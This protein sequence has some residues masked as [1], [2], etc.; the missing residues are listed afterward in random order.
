MSSKLYKKWMKARTAL[1]AAT[2]NESQ[3]REEIMLGMEDDK[4]KVTVGD[5]IVSFT[6]GENHSIPKAG[7][8]DIKSN[9]K[10]DVFESVFTT[11]YKLKPAVYNAMSGKAKKAIDKH[12]VIKPAP[13][14]VTVN[15]V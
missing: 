6:K 4:L 2:L 5:E 11:S 15:P 13:L 8:L 3:L 14:K 12:L 9:I 7:A 1:A 10:S